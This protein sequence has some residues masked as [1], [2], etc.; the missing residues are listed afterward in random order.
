MKKSLILLSIFAF[1][2]LS[3][4][5]WKVH[6]WSHPGKTFHLGN[7]K[8]GT[9]DFQIWQRKNEGFAEPFTTA[10][11]VRPT[12][13]RLWKAYSLG[14]QDFYTPPVKLEH[15]DSE[16]EVFYGDKSLGVFDLTTGNYLRAGQLNPI[17]EGGTDS[18]EKWWISP[19]NF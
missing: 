4:L 17:E 10:L 8:F 5:S 7:W 2:G 14:H 3:W 19:E 13:S 11:F 15:K 16:V 18:P 6:F 12:G 9:Y 1:I